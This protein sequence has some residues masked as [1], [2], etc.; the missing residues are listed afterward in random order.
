MAAESSPPLLSL[1]PTSH[2]SPARLD[3]DMCLRVMKPSPS[4]P[5][6]SND[7]PSICASVASAASSPEQARDHPHSG[8]PLSLEEKEFFKP[9]LED[10]DVFDSEFRPQSTLLNRRDLMK[11]MLV[12]AA[13]CFDWK[14]YRA[15]LSKS[16]SDRE[17]PLAEGS[18]RGS[19]KI[20]I[21][22]PVLKGITST[23]Q[24]M[25][26]PNP[27]WLGRIFNALQPLKITQ[28]AD[29]LIIF[30]IVDRLAAR[31]CT[32]GTMLV[33]FT[34]QAMTPAIPSCSVGWHIRNNATSMAATDTVPAGHPLKDVL[35]SDIDGI[36]VVIIA[37]LGFFIFVVMCL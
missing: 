13:I 22:S 21:E 5:C 4:P 35:R 23:P 25:L 3:N 28:S 7:S 15:I 19:E 33:A 11:L 14:A 12:I 29:S 10:D 30:N 2:R 34:A 9:W 18:L 20:A 27:L 26:W 37:F 8:P 17:N 6:S 1:S 16:L 32:Y 31:I 24:G 36:F